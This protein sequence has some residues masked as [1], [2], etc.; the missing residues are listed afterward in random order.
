MSRWIVRPAWLKGLAS[1]QMVPWL[2][3]PEIQRV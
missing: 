1:G 2:V 3:G